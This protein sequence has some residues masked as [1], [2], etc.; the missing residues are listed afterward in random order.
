MTG[1][2]D[3]EFVQAGEWTRPTTGRRVQGEARRGDSGAG[4]LECWLTGEDAVQPWGADTTTDAGPDAVPLN[5]F[6]AND[7]RVDRRYRAF[8][9]EVAARKKAAPES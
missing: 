8:V 1:S 5:G 6:R 2:Y 4:L 9:A 7:Y 3:F